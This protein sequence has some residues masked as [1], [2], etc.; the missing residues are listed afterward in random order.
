M[1]R[2]REY[3]TAARRG[4][5]TESERGSGDDMKGCAGSKT[6]SSSSLEEC[7]I[8]QITKQGGKSCTRWRR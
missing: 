1:A 5:G 2:L 6:V 7:A 4:R 8:R 3:I